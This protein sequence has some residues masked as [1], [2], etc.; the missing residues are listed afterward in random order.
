MLARNNNAY[1]LA[2][3][4]PSSLDCLATGYLSLAL[5]P[6]LHS[7]WLRD[8]MLSKAPTVAAYI[9]QMRGECFGN[10]PVTTDLA[11][12]PAPNPK[13]P[14]Q[15][16][17]RPSLPKIGSTLLTTLADAT[18]ILRDFRTNAR[19]KQMAEAADSGL[20]EEDSQTLSAYA[21]QNKS[22]MFLSIAAV[23]AGVVALVGYMVHVGLFEG[24]E[25]QD[26]EGEGEGMGDVLDPN[27]TA[28]FL[29]A[30]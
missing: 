7:P 8:A 6:D 13:L 22:D 11:L 29:S 27:S 26:E 24:Q 18:P 28:D 16:P 4:Q 19:V 3:E 5:I 10:D 2:T 20:S 30:L 25:E 15:A 14:W 17:E 9:R 1:F 23:G 12:N 21:R